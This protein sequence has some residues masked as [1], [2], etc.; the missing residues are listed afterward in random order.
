MKLD[1]AHDLNAVAHVDVV[2]K[3]LEVICRSTG[4]GFAAVAR[5][6]DERWIACA[7]RDE[8]AFGLTPGGELD[9][10]STICDE[11]RQSGELVVID[12]V[13]V[14]QRFCKHPTPAKYGFRSY[15]S[16]P[17]RYPDGRFF[18]TLCAIDPRPAR[19]ETPETVG[20]FTMFADLIGFH[21][22]AYERLHASESALRVERND[23]VLRDQFI[24]VLGHDLRNPLTAIWTS[25][26]VLSRMPLP[27]GGSR[28]VAIIQR[29]TVRMNGLV[30]NL[31]DLARAK[32]GEGLPVVTETVDDLA[33]T[34]DD[35][36]AELAAGW[37]HRLIETD[38]LITAPVT[39]DRARIAQLLSNLIANALAHGDAS[40]MVMVRA[41]T[42]EDALTLSVENRG[43]AI[44]PADM[45]RL[46]QPFARGNARAKEGLGL[47][48]FIAAEIARAHAGELTATS[49]QRVTCF[50]LRIPLTR[51][52]AAA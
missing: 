37:P 10:R 43:A 44:A 46:F 20:M 35:V 29:G 40:G 28:T 4:M 27:A 17:L 18:G 34:I 33:A 13:A 39:C 14:D 50:T 25:A 38:V 15:I 52:I 16:V 48:L 32:I 23:A 7:V 21:L 22:D 12:D 30:E 5:V 51:A 45:A 9:I 1:Y 6:T 19:I 8:I 31:M 42:T 47:G 26:E 24:A 2:P 3:I 41:R 49:D 11:I 36:V